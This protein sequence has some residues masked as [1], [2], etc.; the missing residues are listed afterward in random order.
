MNLL[1][2]VKAA[3]QIL[4]FNFLRANS[5]RMREAANGRPP[6]L[7]GKRLALQRILLLTLAHS[8]LAVSAFAT[9]GAPRNAIEAENCLPGNPSSQWYVWGTG[10]K[11]IQGFT[12]DIS[13]NAGQTD[14]GNWAV[15]ASWAVPA[16]A[17]SGIYQASLVRL[18]TG[19]VGQ[20]LF[21]VRNDSSHSNI[22]VQTS[23][24]NWQAY[25]DYG[26]NSL[27]SGNPA[28]RAY[29]V[30]YNRPFNVPNL[31]AWFF[32][33]EYPMIRWLEANESSGIPTRKT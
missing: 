31:N 17:T 4:L 9:C 21:V 18:D 16:T 1:S 29:K 32:A 19:D 27:Y 6:A 26:G 15:S 22:L 23:D 13:V 12:T 10:S 3:L 14:C 11:N 8:L 5:A 7:S 25:N 30:S 2:C 28:G 33:S 20:I 24:L